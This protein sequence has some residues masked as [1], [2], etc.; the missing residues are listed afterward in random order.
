MLK[1]IAVRI[2]YIDDLPPW[3]QIWQ[4]DDSRDP[5]VYPLTDIMRPSAPTQEEWW[6]MLRRAESYV[7]A[8]SDSS[9]SP[10]HS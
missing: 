8:S 6:E 5:P 4:C 10:H 3:V 1:P 7:F 9:E 2:T